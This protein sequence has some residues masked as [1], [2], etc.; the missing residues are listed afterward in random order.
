MKHV[1]FMVCQYIIWAFTRRI[2]GQI[3]FLECVAS[4]CFFQQLSRYAYVQVST[5]DLMSERQLN[6]N[7]IHVRKL[8]SSL[9]LLCNVPTSEYDF[10]PK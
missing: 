1:S 7:Y 9:D 3:P 5:P 4:T 6:L 8:Q 2:T 10:E